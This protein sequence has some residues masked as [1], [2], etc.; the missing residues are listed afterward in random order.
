MEKSHRDEASG[1]RNSGVF[2]W[3][4]H[5]ERT[6]EHGKGRSRGD[7]QMCPYAGCQGDAVID[8]WEWKKLRVHH[9]DYPAIPLVGMRYRLFRRPA[10]D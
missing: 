5:C 2:L 6:C 3:C 4:T 8:T 10:S 9:P 1:Q 7:V